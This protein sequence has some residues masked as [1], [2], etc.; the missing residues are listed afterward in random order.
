MADWEK[1]INMDSLKELLRNPFDVG[2]KAGELGEDRDVTFE[3]FWEGVLEKLE[4]QG[5]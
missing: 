2:Y 5:E 1:F 4:E 3:M